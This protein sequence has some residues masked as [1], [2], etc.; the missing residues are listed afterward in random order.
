MISGNMPPKSEAMNYCMLCFPNYNLQF[1]VLHL[2]CFSVFI[3][4]LLFLCST[5]PSNTSNYTSDTITTLCS[6]LF[7]ISYFFIFLPLSFCLPPLYHSLLL[8]HPLSTSLFCSFNPSSS[9]FFSLP[10]VFSLPSTLCFLISFVP[11]S[12]ATTL[13][14]FLPLW[15]WEWLFVFK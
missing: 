10:L 1:W 12:S 2:S 6:L 5:V 14:H 7:L 11:F 9:L 3:I 4:S 13:Q 15:G 8:S